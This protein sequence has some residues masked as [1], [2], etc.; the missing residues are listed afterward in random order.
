M[1][2]CRIVLYYVIYISSCYIETYSGRL[3]RK[4]KYNRIELDSELHTHMYIYIH[5]PIYV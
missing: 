2:C 5:M 4:D 3:Y 1:I